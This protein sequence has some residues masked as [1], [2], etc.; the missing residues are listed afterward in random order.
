M[1]K[2]TVIPMIGVGVDPK[3]LIN[4]L[5]KEAFAKCR[6]KLF[7]LPDGEQE[8]IDVVASE[9][10]AIADYIPEM[11]NDR[12][13]IPEG[14]L[15]TLETMCKG[16]HVDVTSIIQELDSN[17]KGKAFVRIGQGE[18]RPIDDVWEQYESYAVYVSFTRFWGSPDWVLD[19]FKGNIK[20]I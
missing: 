14:D 1:N 16:W 11:Y 12:I 17:F 8:F 15:I 19:R 7:F 18:Y 20:P 2:E 9:I 5:A 13:Y 6:G 10:L 3:E 4:K